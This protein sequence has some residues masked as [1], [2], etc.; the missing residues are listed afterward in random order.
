MYK[1]RKREEGFTLIEILIVVIIIGFLTAM[2]GPRL[3]NRVSQARQT[4]AHN[5]L[6][7]FKLA[8][9]NYRLDNGRY[10]TTE[11]GLEA[12]VKKPMSAPVPSNWAGP[13][14]DANQVPKD[15][16]GHKYHYKY[17]GD[18][19]DYKYDLWSWGGDNKEGGEGEDA[20]ITNW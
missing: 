16:W 18:N 14:L 7:I 3:F 6:D 20:D 12:L 5:Q 19:N 15:P 17:P 9:D 13:Y 11:Q 4:A 1:L 8:L 2:V 10:P